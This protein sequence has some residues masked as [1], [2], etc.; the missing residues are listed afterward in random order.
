MRIGFIT[1]VF[2]LVLAVTGFCVG[3]DS[4]DLDRSMGRQGSPP[5]P[6]DYSRA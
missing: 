3:I 5:S 4:Y 1:M 6:A 2:G